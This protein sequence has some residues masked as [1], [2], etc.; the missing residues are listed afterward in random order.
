M[1]KTEEIEKL[2]SLLRKIPHPEKGLPQEVFRALT[3]IVPFC[4]CELVVKNSQGEMLLTWRH[5][6]WWKGWHFPGG[7]MRFG[8]SFGE[9][10][11]RTVKR[12]LGVKLKKFQFLFPINYNRGPRGHGVSLVFLCKLSGTPKDGRYFAKMPKNLITIHKS[13]WRSIKKL[14]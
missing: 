5:D 1:L 4:A 11:R 13:L 6:E 10:L 9:S 14:L 8:E 12:E 7:L 2:A 3:R